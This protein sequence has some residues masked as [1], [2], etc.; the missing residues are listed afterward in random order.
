ME[1]HVRWPERGL[2]VVRV[3][4]K[5]LSGRLR[6]SQEF[7]RDRA[8]IA[9]G[10][11]IRH[12][13]IEHADETQR[14]RVAVADPRGW[15]VLSPR[16]VARG[17][18]AAVQS[19]LRTV[20]V[21]RAPICRHIP[22]RGVDRTS[23]VRRCEKTKAEHR[24]RVARIVEAA[25]AGD[26]PAEDVDWANGILASRND[27]T[28]TD[29][30]GE[31]VAGAGALGEAILARDPDFARTVA[32][33]RA[34]VSHPGGKHGLSSVQRYWYG[35]VLLWVVRARLAGEAGLATDLM[36]HQVTKRGSFDHAV[37]EIGPH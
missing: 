22:K 35:E 26:V 7:G 28:L 24:Q 20:H 34:R 2:P 14:V 30:I 33:A 5:L 13:Q 12:A 16:W 32:S 3:G 29:L 21:L 10:R 9:P 17:R 8:I 23:Q 15:L 31:L 1:H 11:G 27:K 4:A 18:N 6:A 19:V 37:S 25:R 36:S